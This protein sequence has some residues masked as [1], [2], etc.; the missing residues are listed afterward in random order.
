MT[1]LP[2]FKKTVAFADTDMA[3]IVHFSRI[4]CYVE[5][6]EHTA[7]ATMG[8]LAMTPEGGF[9]KVHVECD[10]RSP[11]RF[12][13]KVSIELGLCRIGDCSLT[14]KFKVECAGQV[15]AEGNFV[16]VYINNAG[17]SAEIPLVYRK[18]LQLGCIGEVP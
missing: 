5:E 10:Y 15:A 13:E 9:P 7:M 11:L 17:R 12:G 14:W 8:V 18:L 3:G 1:K 6:A 4:L 16:T 2:P